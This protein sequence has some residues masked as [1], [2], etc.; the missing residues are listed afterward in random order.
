MTRLYCITHKPLNLP[1]TQAF[2]A[3]QVGDSDQQ[4]CRLRDNSGENIAGKNDTWSENTAFYQVWKNRPWDEVGFCHYRRFLLPN[5]MRKSLSEHFTSPY[6]DPKHTITTHNY[7]SGFKVSQSVLFEEFEK[8]GMG[9]TEA[10]HDALATGDIVLPRANKL[11]EGG[12]MG[13]YG[14][15]HPTWPF[16][17]LLSIMSRQNNN[18]ARDAMHFFSF[19]PKAHWNN[20]FYTHWHFFDD[21][22]RFM[23]PLLRALEVKIDVPKNPYQKRVFAFLSERLFNFW[24][25]NRELKVVE[26]DW[27]MTESPTDGEDSH[28]WTRAKR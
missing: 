7:A 24:V 21:Y 8:Q 23:F 9:Y 26:M 4:F 14:V 28:H 15:S 25:W 13:Q 16:H 6:N 19:H 22:C 1:E 27:C 2:K 18:L 11:P 12:F 17:E 20:L 10:L 3:M 5:M